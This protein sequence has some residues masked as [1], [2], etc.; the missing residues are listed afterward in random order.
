M[1]ERFG[2]VEFDV[3]FTDGGER[4]FADGVVHGFGKKLAQDFGTDLVFVARANDGARRV[5]W[6]E[7]RDLRG[8]AVLIADA[9]VSAA[10]YGRL[11]LDTD[12]FACW[13]DV[14]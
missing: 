6:S 2:V 9:I 3:W 1:F 13:G 11:D 12:L 10:H 14:C 8:L 4:V 5:S 7:A